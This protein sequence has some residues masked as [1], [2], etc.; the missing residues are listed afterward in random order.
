MNVIMNKKISITKPRANL[1]PVPVTLV[2]CAYEDMENILTVSWTGIMNSHPPMIYI[3]IRP[4][5][6]SYTL[7]EKSRRFCLNIPSVSMLKE[8]D[9]CG[10]V[11]GSGYDK[12]EVCRFDLITLVEGYPKAIQQCKQHLFCDV[13]DVLKLGSHAAFIGEVKYEFINEDCLC[14]QKSLK[15]DRLN[16]IAYCRKNYYQLSD[17]I[18]TYG[19]V[20]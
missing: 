7:L 8:V 2:S 3:S 18:G 16:P 15:Y 6:F 17:K 20:K 9:F 1:Y 5:R 14:N 13:I 12:A 19:Q 10:N 11:S 4:E